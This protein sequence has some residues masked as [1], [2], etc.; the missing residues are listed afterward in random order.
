MWCLRIKYVA[1]YLHEKIRPCKDYD[2]RRRKHNLSSCSYYFFFLSNWL[3]LFFQC[4]TT[5]KLQCKNW[6][7]IMLQGH[8]ITEWWSCATISI[9]YVSPAKRTIVKKYAVWVHSVNFVASSAKKKTIVTKT[10][11]VSPALWS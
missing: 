10:P 9:P 3:Y 6:T 4:S 1:D 11:C 7:S 2:P 8:Q 5:I